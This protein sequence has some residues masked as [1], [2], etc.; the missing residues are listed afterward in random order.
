MIYAKAKPVESLFSRPRNR[1]LQLCLSWPGPC[2]M[3]LRNDYKVKPYIM[4]LVV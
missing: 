1:I 3:L 4:F 2:N